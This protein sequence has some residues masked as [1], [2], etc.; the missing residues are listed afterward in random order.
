MKRTLL[1]CAIGVAA[2][3]QIAGA[4]AG[5]PLEAELDFETIILV[6]PLSD[7]DSDIGV[8]PVLGELSLNGNVEKVLENGVRLRARTASST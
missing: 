7:A 8:E 4:Q 3:S 1:S 5:A 6:T 2:S